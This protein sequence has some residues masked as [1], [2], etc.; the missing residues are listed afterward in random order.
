MKTKFDTNIT[1]NSFTRIHGT[2]RVLEHI[3]ERPVSTDIL[4]IIHRFQEEN[5]AIFQNQ[6]FQSEYAKLSVD[7]VSA[8]LC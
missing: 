5:R 6:A 7:N 1:A 4:S 3:Q 8:Q 2:E